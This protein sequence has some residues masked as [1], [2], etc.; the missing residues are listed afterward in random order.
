[1]DISSDETDEKISTP[2]DH[3]NNTDHYSPPDPEPEGASM[4]DNQ[5]SGEKMTQESQ[6]IILTF[7]D[8]P[9]ID[10]PVDPKVRQ[11]AM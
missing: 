4:A 11:E 2:S 8:V 3:S 6:Q 9:P 7:V 10:D 1:M 5:S